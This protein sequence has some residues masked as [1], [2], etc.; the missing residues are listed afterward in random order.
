MRRMRNAVPVLPIPPVFAVRNQIRVPP[1]RR[2]RS[3]LPAFRGLTTQASNLP[4]LPPQ[5]EVVGVGDSVR[6]VAWDGQTKLGADAPIDAASIRRAH[7]SVPR[8]ST[9]C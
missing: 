3:P 8:D 9:N 7:T 6:G 5:E 4:D 2:L 1:V